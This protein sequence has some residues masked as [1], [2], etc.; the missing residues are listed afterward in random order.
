MAQKSVSDTP[1]DY[2]HAVPVTISG[3]NAV[4]QLRLPQAVYLHARSAEL[5][6]LRIFNGSGKSLPFTLMAPASQA[7]ANRREQPATLFPVLQGGAQNA[8]ANKDFKIHTSSDGAVISVT[9]HIGGKVQKVAD[10][11]QLDTLVLDMGK[12]DTSTRAA[13]DALTFALPAGMDN[14]HAQVDLETSDDLRQWEAL[15]YANLSWMSNSEQKTLVSNRME[16]APRAF[17]YARLTWRDGKPLKF[18]AIVAES[19]TLTDVAPEEM[20]V[21]LK[22]ASGKF[23]GDLVYASALAIPVRRINVQLDNQNVVLPALLGEYVELPALKGSTATRWEFRPSVQA[24]F[25]QIL[26]DGKQRRSGDVI[27]GQ[28]H[29]SNW[30]L[31]SPAAAGAQPMLKLSWVPDTLVFMASGPGPYTLS[32]GRDKID[33]AQRGLEQVAPGFSLLELSKV[34]QAQSGPVQAAAV[35]KADDSAA[36]QAA[37]AATRRMWMLWGVLLLGV[38]VLGV[39]AWK[40]VGQMKSEVSPD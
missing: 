14:Y 31:R 38:V 30:V 3:N 9:T 22:P 17:R 12:S 33:S 23:D 28:V 24:T 15:G 10:G 25:F 36:Q 5:R 7:Q 35:A 20:S 29:Q 8:A 6:D 2:T 11:A 18:A 4:V 19:S 37:D 40:L 13:Y 34:E 39:M 27:V 1:A 32:M 16:F 26:Q 21:L